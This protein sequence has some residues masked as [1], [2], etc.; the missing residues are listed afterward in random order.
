MPYKPAVTKSSYDDHSNEIEEQRYD[1]PAT[2]TATTSGTIYHIYSYDHYIINKDNGSRDRYLVIEY[3]GD[4]SM[5]NYK[6]LITVRGDNQLVSHL[7][8]DFL[9]T[10]CALDF[11]EI[12]MS[13][14]G[15]VVQRSVTA[16]SAKN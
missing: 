10:E 3:C 8:M 15:I 7:N 9:C 14:Y 4:I 12:V 11:Y 5:N 6:P 1:F 2:M 16:V 13:I